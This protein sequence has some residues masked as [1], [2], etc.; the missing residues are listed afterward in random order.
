MSYDALVLIFL[1]YIRNVA[2]LFVNNGASVIIL[3]CW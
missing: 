2:P 1:L 3:P